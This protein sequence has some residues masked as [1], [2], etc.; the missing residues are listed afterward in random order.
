MGH[1]YDVARSRRLSS[2]EIP[3]SHS[4]RQY[5]YAVFVL[6]VELF[7]GAIQGFSDQQDSGV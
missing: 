1:L 6:R 7:S 5:F 2:P 3:P 4:P